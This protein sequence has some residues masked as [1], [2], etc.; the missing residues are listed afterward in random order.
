[1]SR[2]SYFLWSSMPDEEL[3][4]AAAEHR[5]RKPG[6]LAAEVKRMLADAKSKRL[7]ENF[8]GQW[9]ELRNLDSVKPDPKSFPDFDDQ[10]RAAM[11]SETELFFANLV[12]ED[13][14]ILDFI[15]GKYTFLNE[16]LAKHYGIDGVTGREFRRVEL[17]GAERSGILTQASILTVT[18]YPNRSS[19]VL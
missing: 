9:L 16:R 18:S 4:R 3:Y 13:R 6:V 19:P 17:D 7:V 8:A 10:L 11:R 1:A 14:S 5:L 12:A 15:D 2:L